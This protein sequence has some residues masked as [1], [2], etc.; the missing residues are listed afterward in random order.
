MSPRGCARVMSHT[1]IATRWPGTHELAERRAIERRPDRAE[2]RRMRVRDRGS[3][4]R[5]D[6]GDAFVGKIDLEAVGSVVQS[7]SHPVGQLR[8]CVV[9]SW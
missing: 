6:D 1:E 4:D 3:R 7:Y 5:L 9:G 8:S 2:Q